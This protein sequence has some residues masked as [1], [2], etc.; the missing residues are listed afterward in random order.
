MRSVLNTL[1]PFGSPGK[2]SSYVFAFRFLN[3]SSNLP[4]LAQFLLF[5]FNSKAPGG[6]VDG[7]PH[8][9]HKNPNPT[10]KHRYA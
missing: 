6:G 4:T 2:T 9:P 8:I 3:R 5:V 7:A 1:A 10:I